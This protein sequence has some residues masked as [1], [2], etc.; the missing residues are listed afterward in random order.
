MKTERMT[1]LIKTGMYGDGSLAVQWKE[2]GI[3]DG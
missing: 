3:R 2:W 1:A